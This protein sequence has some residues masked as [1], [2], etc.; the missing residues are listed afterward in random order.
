MTGHR[1]LRSKRVLNSGLFEISF[2]ILNICTWLP[3]T[4]ALLHFSKQNFAHFYSRV[5]KSTDTSLEKN[6]FL[7]KFPMFL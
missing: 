6:D 1:E 3:V 2:E 7:S 4:N 5:L